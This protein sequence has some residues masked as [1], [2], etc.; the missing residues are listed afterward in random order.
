MSASLLIA[1]SS[2]ASACPFC[3]TV[4][5]TLSEHV[6]AADAAVIAHRVVGAS[7]SDRTFRI[8]RVLSGSESVG[9]QRKIEALYF[10]DA[11]GDQ[12]FLIFG[13]KVPELMWASPLPLSDEAFRYLNQQLELPRDSHERVALALK[14]LASDEKILQQDAYDEFA[15]APYDHLHLIKDELDAVDLIV[16]IKDKKTPWER[17]RLFLTLL[18]VCSSDEHVAEVEAMI[19]SHVKTRQSA[20][21][22]LAACYMTMRGAEAL[23]LLEEN[24]LMSEEAEQMVR[25]SAIISALR[26]H[27]ERNKEVPR[28][29]IVEVLE[30]TLARPQLAGKVL[31]DLTRWKDWSIVDE[32]AKLYH[33]ST[34]EA[35]W[36]KASAFRYLEA[37][38][39]PAAKQYVAAILAADPEARVRA[40]PYFPIQSTPAVHRSGDSRSENGAEGETRAGESTTAILRIAANVNAGT[41][42]SKTGAGQMEAGRGDRDESPAQVDNRALQVAW[43]AIYPVAAACLL[44]LVF[45]VWK[46]DRSDDDTDEDTADNVDLAE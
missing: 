37:C 44:V 34:G 46:R 20:L 32:V 29:A 13:N 1:W 5:Q 17:R 6:D 28:K 7:G 31:V 26:F 15:R 30:R 40:R 21:D 39:L 42:G 8:V 45:W 9:Q 16:Q 43:L 38:P 14:Y 10:G 22:A 33:S 11:S 19:E 35:E 36:V 27:G 4:R 23:P 25:A 3:E 18:G 12:K 41:G 2:A 24:F